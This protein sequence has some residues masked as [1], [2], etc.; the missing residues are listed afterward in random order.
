MGA[1][2]K[3]YVDVEFYSEANLATFVDEQRQ[4]W[5]AS[6]DPLTGD[7]VSADGRE[8]LIDQGLTPLMISFNGPEFGVDAHGWSL[9]YT[10]DVSG[11]PQVWEAGL[12]PAGVERAP[13]TSDKIS[14]LSVLASKDASAN[15]KRLLYSSGGA[16]LADGKLT[17]READNRGAPETIVDDT[18]VGARWIDGTRSFTYVRK[19]S[20]GLGQVIIYNTETAT[21]TTVTATSGN[22]G[23]TYGWIA[24]EYCE[25]L[26]LA[27]VNKTSIEIYRDTG[28]PGWQ[29][30]STLNVPAGSLYNIIGSP[31]P[32]VAGGKSYISLVTRRSDGY[33]PAEVW[34]WGIEEGNGRLVLRCDDGQGDVIR[35][36]PETYVGQNE[37]FVFYNLV[38]KGASGQQVFELYRWNTGVRSR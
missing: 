3:S 22:A 36:D 25:T 17:W 6:L 21:E 31:E 20:P 24:P 37:V 4:A 7:F 16:T 27:V 14:R 11:V 38:R 5:L 23:Y 35:S 13:V 30:I 15:G 28:G 12:T 19:T 26:V 29:L 34:V 32:F 33:S 9:Y 8:T 1:L 18:D 10:K 2:G